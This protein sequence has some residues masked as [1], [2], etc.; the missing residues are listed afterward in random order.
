MTACL[1]RNVS[2]KLCEPSN[3]LYIGLQ[4]HNGKGG[5]AANI[6]LPADYSGVLLSDSPVAAEQPK[7]YAS[8]ASYA[9]SFRKQFEDVQESLRLEGQ[10][11]NEIRIKSVYLYSE[12]PGTGKTTTASAL[13]NEYLVTHYLGS[14]KRGTTPKQRP[15]Y[16]LDVNELQTK[17]TEFNRPKVPQD[18]AEKA[19]EAYY[20]AIEKAKHTDFVVLDDIGVR[21]STEG[22]R[23]DLHSVINHRVSNRLPTVYTSN[24]LI[25]ELPDV[26]GE[27]RL[28]D[29]VR[30]MCQEIHFAGESKRGKRR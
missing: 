27:E 16:F 7:V 2:D 3:P 13:L 28:A 23:G 5:R 19:A 20:R 14:L 29:R 10:S 4:G 11:E 17:Y 8:L 26:F 24:V 21:E 18:I 15:C 22:W 6:G 30:D 1:L 12:E 9:E 25:S